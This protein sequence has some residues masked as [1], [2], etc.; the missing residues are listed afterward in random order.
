VALGDYHQPSTMGE[1]AST[2]TSIDKFRQRCDR[3]CVTR[4]KLVR[5]S[6][7]CSL[8][9]MLS[10]RF[11]AYPHILNSVVHPKRLNRMEFNQIQGPMQCNIIDIYDDSI[12]TENRLS[13][14]YLT[15]DEFLHQ[16]TQLRAEN[17]IDRLQNLR[18]RQDTYDIVRSVHDRVNANYARGVHSH[19]YLLKMYVLSNTN[20]FSGLLNA[21]KIENLE[22]KVEGVNQM[23][24]ELDGKIDSLS[25]ECLSSKQQLMEEIPK[26]TEKARKKTNC[27][28][29]Q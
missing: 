25:R 11:W 16:F 22:H 21:E 26:I 15:R 19:Y 13:D 24:E 3:L 8:Y 6:A 10:L 14:V 12:Q 5:S 9:L 23:F 4:G 7:S 17:K 28:L 1:T 2:S 18:E 29:Y 20:L 27:A